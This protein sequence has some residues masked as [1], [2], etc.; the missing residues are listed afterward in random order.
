MNSKL[1]I[2]GVG[3]SLDD[4]SYSLNAL[5]YVLNELNKSGAE[6]RLIDIKE[7][8]LPLFSYAKTRK[9]AKRDIKNFMDLLHTSDGL[10][11]SSP[12]Y[13]GTV[14]AAFKNFIDH[15]EYLSSY[16]PPYLTLKPIGCISLGGG[17]N[18]GIYTLNT[19]INIVHSLR[20]VTV[21]GNVAIPNAKN[22][23]D[24]KGKLRNENIKRKLKRLAGDVYYVSSKLSI[25]SYN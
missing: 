8:N 24:E 7:C 16:D 21:S 1:L 5:T 20:G 9:T 11:F 13:H 12:E 2:T 17:D 18:S 15:L 6:T 19:L 4:I 25:K 3:G 10:I 23:F 22:A 14:S